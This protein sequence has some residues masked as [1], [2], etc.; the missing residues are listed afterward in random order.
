MKFIIFLTICLSV[1]PHSHE[2][3]VTSGIVRR[4]WALTKEVD[5]I[6]VRL[7]WF[8]NEEACNVWKNLYYKDQKA[9][10]ILY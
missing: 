3:D 4:N 1:F 7:A 9:E 6:K 8:R 5:G 10:C 2:W